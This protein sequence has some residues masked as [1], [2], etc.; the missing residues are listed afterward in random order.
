MQDERRRLWV[1]AAL[2]FG[3][4]TVFLVVIVVV[5]SIDQPTRQER[6]AAHQ[7]A[8]GEPQSLPEPDYG[9]AP[10]HPGDPGGWEQLALLGVLVVAL[11]GG[12]AWVVHSSRRAR[13]NR[14]QPPTPPA[15]DAQEFSG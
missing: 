12:G 10:K 5:A 15:Q 9:T 6:Q 2:I 8:L 11:G 1:A 14:G 13:S 4:I 7:R 3:V